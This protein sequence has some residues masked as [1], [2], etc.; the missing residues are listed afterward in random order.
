MLLIMER[1]EDECIIEW[2]HSSKVGLKGWGNEK[3]KISIGVLD[4]S[5]RTNA[6]SSVNDGCHCI[7]VRI[8]KLIEKG[9]VT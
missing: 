1:E 4:G 3:C 7:K 6:F 2:E 5:F 8:N 9:S